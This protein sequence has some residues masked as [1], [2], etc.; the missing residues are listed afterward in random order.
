MEKKEVEV[1]KAQDV[2]PVA[3]PAKSPC[4]TQVKEYQE[5]LQGF[6]SFFTG[7][8]K[9]QEAFKACPEF[10]S[11]LETSVKKTTSK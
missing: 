2:Q 1:P 4:A 7:C 6:T 9:Q 11:W 3:A 8:K 10:G 5:C